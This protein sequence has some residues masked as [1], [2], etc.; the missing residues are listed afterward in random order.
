MVRKSPE[1][2]QLA[3]HLA[4]WR[5]GHI[6]HL[7]QFL[8]FKHSKSYMA[9]ALA[10]KALHYASP[11]I[12]IFYLPQLFQAMRWDSSKQIVSF[13]LLQSQKSASIAHNVLWFCKVESQ[14]E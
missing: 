9:C 14:L 5:L 12:V 7:A 4:F 13:L 10:L 2:T 6:L 1:S 11:K 8:S 3:K